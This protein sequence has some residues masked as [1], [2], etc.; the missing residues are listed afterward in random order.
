M[1]VVAVAV[2]DGRCCCLLMLRLLLVV[3]LFAVAAPWGGQRAKVHLQGNC[4]H[5]MVAEPYKQIVPFGLK[6]LHISGNNDND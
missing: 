2:A 5:Q 4:I 6:T 1:A 3:L